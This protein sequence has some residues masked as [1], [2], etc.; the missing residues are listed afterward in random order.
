[1]EIKIFYLRKK[2]NKINLIKL[3]AISKALSNIQWVPIMERNFT[4]MN[5]DNDHDNDNDDE[6]DEDYHQVCIVK[7][8]KNKIQY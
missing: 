7:C 4:E 5:D 8:C 1:M 2:S 6:D 3:D